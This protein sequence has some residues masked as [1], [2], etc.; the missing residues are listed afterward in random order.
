MKCPDWCTATHD[1]L[2]VQFHQS[3]V[4]WA[5]PDEARVFTYAGQMESRFAGADPAYVRAVADLGKKMQSANFDASSA[6]A[7]AAIVDHLAASTAADHQA[8]ADAL[9]AN[10]ARIDRQPGPEAEA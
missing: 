6:L 10:A 5:G 4:T 1:E 2:S 3:P 7:L 8:F 9:R